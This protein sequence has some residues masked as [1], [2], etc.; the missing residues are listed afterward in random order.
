MGCLDEG[1]G[2]K[3]SGKSSRSNGMD[4]SGRLRLCVWSRLQGMGMGRRRVDR[5]NKSS[6]SMEDV[7]GVATDAQGFNECGEAASMEKRDLD[8]GARSGDFHCGRMK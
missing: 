2:R 3:G 8:G 4:G 6:G 1:G 7:G 5:C